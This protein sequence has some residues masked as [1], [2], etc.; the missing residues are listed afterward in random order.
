[1]TKIRKRDTGE[2]GNRGEFGTVRRSD[3]DV[4]VT[5][6]T[7]DPLVERFGFDVR[8]ADPVEFDEHAQAAAQ[9]AS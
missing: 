3:A 5:P 4:A 7:P 8:T 6:D 9:E 2:Q 1:M